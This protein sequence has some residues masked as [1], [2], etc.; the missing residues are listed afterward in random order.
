MFSILKKALWRRYLKSLVLSA[1]LM[2]GM[3]A[4]QANETNDESSQFPSVEQ[5]YNKFLANNGGQ[6]NLS[7]MISVIINGH[8]DQAGQTLDYKFYRKRPNK[9]KIQLELDDF[10]LNTIFDGQNGWV[11]VR[12]DSGILK[13]TKMEGEELELIK[14]DSS[15]DSPF[16][17]PL[18]NLKYITVGAFETVNGIKTLRMDLDPKGD[19]TYTNIWISLDNYQE[20]KLRKNLTKKQLENPAFKEEKYEDI[21]YEDYRKQDGVH[22]PFQ[23]KHYIGDTLEKV[24]YIDEIIINRG[25]FD[26]LFEVQAP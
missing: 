12:D 13:V 22:L 1:V 17:V 19:F 24:V 21:Y 6:L 10:Q 7:K 23:V 25:I 5:V 3:T 9:L 11:E 18:Q 16:Y 4:A 8:I 14:K 20:I 26:Y 15:F 2:L